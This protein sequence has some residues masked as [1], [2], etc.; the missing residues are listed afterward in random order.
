MCEGKRGGR[1]MFGGGAFGANKPTF[2]AA[3]SGGFGQPAAGGFGATAGG[4]F[5]QPAAGGFGAAKPAAFGAAAGGGFGQPAAGGFGAST[6]GAFGA[7][8]TSGGFGAF[9]KPATSGGFGQ[10]AAGG[11]GASTGG[12]FGAPAG[13]AF[14]AKP[15]FGASTGGAFGAPAAG[16]F[17]QP[18]AGAFG[19]ASTGGAFGASTGGA[20]GAAGAGAFG[21]PT[22]CP[23]TQRGQFQPAP[24]QRAAQGSTPAGT[25]SYQTIVAALP[26]FSPEELRMADYQQGKHKGAAGAPAAGAFGA[27]A[28]TGGAFGAPA[29]TGFGGAG[30]AFGTASTGGAFGAAAPATGGFGGF[31][32]PASSAAAGGFGGFGAAAT[33]GFGAKPATGGFGGFGASTGA[34]TGG[35]GGFGAAASTGGGFG[36]ASSGGFGGF[37]AA[38]GAATGGFGGF[39]AKPATGG[40]GGFGA[41][42]GGFGAAASTG[43]FGGFGASSGAATGGFGGF[44]ASTGATGGFGGFG[45]KP[46]T[47]G[48]GGFGASTSGGF[49]GFGASTGAATGGFGG[50]GA[51]PATGG[52]GGFGA[53]TGGGFGGFGAKPATGAFG[54]FGAAT[55]GGFGM[56]MQQPMAA[57]ANMGMG[58][59]M[60]NPAAQMQMQ[61]AVLGGMQSETNPLGPSPFDK[62]APPPIADSSKPSSKTSTAVVFPDTK[63]S[64]EFVNTQA[65]SGTRRGTNGSAPMRPRTSRLASPAQEAIS[66]PGRTPR[67]RAGL[68]DT[69][70]P[71]D[72][73]FGEGALSIS[74]SWAADPRVLTIDVPPSLDA[75]A[76]SGNGNGH[77]FAGGEQVEEEEEE[78][79][80]YTLE[81]NKLSPPP[82]EQSLDSANITVRAPYEPSKL[83]DKW[84]TQSDSH[85]GD[86]P[87]LPDDCFCR[88]S[89][90]EI[91]SMPED[92]RK[93]VV[94]F[95]IGR[96]GFGTICFEGYTD[97]TSLDLTTSIAGEGMVMWEGQRNACT[98]VILYPEDLLDRLGKTKP[99]Q[100]EELNKPAEITLNFQ[101]S[102]KE[103]EIRSGIENGAENDGDKMKFISYN[104]RSGEL[105]FRVKHFTRWGL[106]AAVMDEATPRRRTGV[107]DSMDD[108]DA[109]NMPTESFLKIG[110]HS[111]IRI[112]PSSEQRRFAKPA[113]AKNVDSDSMNEDDPP[114][115][116]CAF[117]DDTVRKALEALGS[118]RDTYRQDESMVDAQRSFFKGMGNST[119]ESMVD[120]DAF[121]P[122]KFAAVGATPGTSSATEFRSGAAIVVAPDRIHEG[123]AFENYPT[124][125]TDPV[126]MPS[127]DPRQELDLPHESHEYSTNDGVVLNCED[128]GARM[129]RSFRV[130]WGPGGMMIYNFTCPNSGGRAPT[131]P[132]GTLQMQSVTA[133]A[134][135]G[136]GTSDGAMTRDLATRLAHRKRE[137]SRTEENEEATAIESLLE[138]YSN[139][140]D[141]DVEKHVWQL[142]RC[143]YLSD[144]S[145]DV[146]HAVSTWL[147]QVTKPSSTPPTIV[148]LLSCR[149]IEKAC[150]AAVEQRDFRLAALIA[151]ADGPSELR[152]ELS[153][154]VK[155]WKQGPG[156]F[157]SQ[158]K[159][160]EKHV[161][162]ILSGD[163]DTTQADLGISP[164]T[165]GWRS[166]LGLHMWYK[167]GGGAQAGTSL[168]QL[169]M[170]VDSYDASWQARKAPRPRPS[171][172]SPSC[173]QDQSHDVCYSLLQ[174]YAQ[175]PISLDPRAHRAAVLDCS[176]VWHLQ[177]LLAEI[178][179]G[180]GS[181][182][183]ALPP[184]QLHTDFI[185][186]L[187]ARGLLRWAIYVATQWQLKSYAV[188]STS[189]ELTPFVLDLLCRYSPALSDADFQWLRD[190]VGLPLGW[191]TYARAVTAASVGDAVEEAIRLAETLG[192]MGGAS[193]FDLLAF[194]KQ[195]QSTL[196][197]EVTLLVDV[198]SDAAG[199][200]TPTPFAEPLCRWARQ[201]LRAV[202]LSRLAPC[203][204]AVP[205]RRSGGE[206]DLGGA[207]ARLLQL[208]DTVSAQ[209]DV[210]LPSTSVRMTAAVGA[211]ACTACALEGAY[212]ASQLVREKTAAAGAVPDDGHRSPTRPRLSPDTDSAGGSTKT[213]MDEDDGDDDLWCVAVLLLVQYVCALVVTDG[214]CAL[215]LISKNALVDLIQ[216]HSLPLPGSSPIAAYQ[217][218]A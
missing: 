15:A 14:G 193:R 151:Q 5:G 204:A 211:S 107:D 134:L 120:A 160:P 177:S 207:L 106:S 171:Y 203:F 155:C 89:I 128:F 9:G 33:G 162:A 187:E 200:A 72:E 110:G 124:K 49:G 87:R 176:F 166:C 167:F 216:S 156:T 111:S 115:S 32:A 133:S 184:Q 202:A 31:G 169:H 3:A 48:F 25:D 101:P 142:V 109:E 148:E 45:A 54:A 194:A 30:G 16:G 57:A 94:D 46:A 175:T 181:V 102:W 164:E 20:F 170:I 206:N 172:A 190:E 145:K 4:G 55:G 2:G 61:V 6:G 135:T 36:A 197:P 125:A 213:P 150:E 140:C 39:G 195:L 108:S 180:G 88:P 96:E 158:M 183:A 127:H 123:Y 149:S 131:M 198:D 80:G 82:V 126:M 113:A 104:E 208:L 129:G 1:G 182:R 116:N 114:D 86:F 23:G 179:A 7:P 37:G 41:S 69:R 163:F 210:A 121:G 165:L 154:Q 189:L 218:R 186:Q 105:K 22:Q 192:Q 34:A 191:L 26:N 67:R 144:A 119:E 77:Q 59:G 17:G 209:A 174:C 64:T 84:K 28:S 60:V 157:W 47:G 168:E 24:V 74:A 117:A 85:E 147:Q 83:N 199:A 214:S 81:K 217:V 13:G 136:D 91:I 62:T 76:T 201:R 185:F 153:K 63:R 98:G 53:S 93:R 40:F 132:I 118:N 122:D 138:Q 99:A 139:T 100:G 27:A 161:Y 143:L 103:E 8:A 78:D 141:S 75:S 42:T 112:T 11:F 21:T 19:A 92:R 38:T 71:A 73:S 95:T 205:R 35:F 173:P 90:D 65:R 70:V 44:G 137:T 10:P 66:S 146:R 68:S 188:E 97:T 196:A 50:F 43:G 178:P 79:D 58:V 159:A 56:G 18:A 215:R 12:A 130:G 29:A 51:K 212:R 152:A 52:F